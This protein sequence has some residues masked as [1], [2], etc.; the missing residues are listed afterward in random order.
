MPVDRLQSLSVRS[1]GHLLLLV[2]VLASCA[3]HF[4]PPRNF[5]A[6]SGEAAVERGGYLAEHVA[7]CVTCHS[8]RDWSRFG[9]PSTPGTEGHGGESFNDL[10]KLP[11]EVSLP[12]PGISPMQVSDWSDGELARAI[13]GGLSR[14][15]TALFPSH[16]Y[17]QYRAM[18]QEDLEAIVAWIRTV[19]PGQTALPERDLKYA[20]VRDMTN[21][22]PKAVKLP[23]RAPSGD[24][25]ARGRYLARLAS[26]RY[27]HSPTDPLG[28]PLP[29][30]EFAGGTAFAVPPP[31]GGRVVVPNITPH[32][33]GIGNWSREDFVRRFRGSGPGG[34][35]AV[36]IEEGGF[37]SPMAWKAYSG[38]SDEDLG[39]IYDYLLTRRPIARTVPR[40][41]PP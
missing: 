12:S 24:S 3:P 37:N 27:C 2:L 18:A 30:Q 32:A 36:A 41:E 9:G 29:G 23:R 10:F 35:E 17:F 11:P 25:V 16:P 15:G 38:M 31:G 40:W 20:M 22:F 6:A 19:E 34:Y 26:C 4:P 21:S 28:F 33:T 7:I 13:V 5:Q 1:A 8:V 39:A 14:D